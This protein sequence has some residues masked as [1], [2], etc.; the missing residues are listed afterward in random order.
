MKSLLRLSAWGCVALLAVALLP[1]AFA[2]TQQA[3]GPYEDIQ[4]LLASAAAS[5]SDLA[6][7][8]A[9]GAPRVIDLHHHHHHVVPANVPAH[10][11]ERIAEDNTPAPPPVRIVEIPNRNQAARHAA[12]DAEYQ[13][14]ASQPS[15]TTVDVQH[16][17]NIVVPSNKVTA[18]IK[19][20]K[21]PKVQPIDGSYTIKGQ[22]GDTNEDAAWKVKGSGFHFPLVDR[23]LQR[24]HF[25]VIAETDGSEKAT[26]F[27]P[28]SAKELQAEAMKLLAKAKKLKAKKT[29]AA[30]KKEAETLGVFD[31]KDDG[32]EDELTRLKRVSAR[33]NRLLEQIETPR[34]D[35]TFEGHIAREKYY[36]KIYS[37]LKKDATDIIEGYALRTG[38]SIFSTFGDG[39]IDPSIAAFLPP[40]SVSAILAQYSNPNRGRTDETPRDLIAGKDAKRIKYAIDYYK[41]K[42]AGTRMPLPP[43]YALSDAEEDALAKHNNPLNNK[44]VATLDGPFGAGRPAITAG[45]QAIGRS[46][47]HIGVVNPTENQKE[48]GLPYQVNLKLKKLH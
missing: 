44:V 48:R 20:A 38:K 41:A 19:D 21:S 45:N 24:P 35:D 7:L 9:P 3:L 43:V 4:N 42:K 11:A 13:R 1:A 39:K 40:N 10:V 25:P 37:Q 18:T 27:K 30:A 29:A 12:E 33:M 15:I 17:V 6:A 47:V 23:G 34:P 5:S 26:N 46:A 31:S 28:H 2:D 8:D 16:S 22:R 14:H 36:L 32:F